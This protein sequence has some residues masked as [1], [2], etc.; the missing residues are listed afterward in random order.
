LFFAVVNVVKLVPYYW[1]GQFSTSNVL[2][3]LLLVPLAPLG[4]WIGHELVK[5]SPA[6]FY[7]R[8]IS[9]FLVVLGARLLWVGLSG[10]VG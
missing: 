3:S 1:L 10:L 2:Y 9:F 8:V 7:Y 6:V 5:R 4:V